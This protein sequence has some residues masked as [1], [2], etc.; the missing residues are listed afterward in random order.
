MSFF[1]TNK[2]IIH[3]RTTRRLDNYMIYAKQ[4]SLRTSLKT[5]AYL[6]FKYDGH[7]SVKHQFTPF[8]K[9]KRQ[10]SKYYEKLYD[11]IIWY[12]IYSVYKYMNIT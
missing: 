3:K 8:C 10:N 4:I 11:K 1:M 5:F 6:V 9:Q 12:Y 7:I 2:Y